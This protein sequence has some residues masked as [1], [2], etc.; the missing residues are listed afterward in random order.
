LLAELGFARQALHAATLGFHHPVRKEFL[1]FES[2]LPV[3]MVDLIARLAGEM[4]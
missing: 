1:S 2:P 4:E 3:D